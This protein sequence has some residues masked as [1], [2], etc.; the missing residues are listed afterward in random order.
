MHSALQFLFEGVKRVSQRVEGLAGMLESF[1][2][3]ENVKEGLRKG[4]VAGRKAA[5]E[6]AEKVLTRLKDL[7]MRTSKRL[8]EFEHL[9][10]EVEKKTL[11]KITECE[12]ALLKKIT[13]DYV[14]KALEQL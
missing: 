11:W 10:K 8:S 7:E 9:T 12:G 3:K 2:T 1:E 5:E 13:P 14:E 6:E 4:G